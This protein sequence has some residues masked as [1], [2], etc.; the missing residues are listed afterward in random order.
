MRHW[1]DGWS[2]LSTYE[3]EAGTGESIESDVAASDND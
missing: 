3:L 2:T 1:P